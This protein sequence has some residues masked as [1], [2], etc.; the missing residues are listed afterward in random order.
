M[1]KTVGILG[2]GQLGRMMCEAA[3]RLNLK[4]VCLDA[5][6]APAK[7]INCHPDHVNGSFR[8]AQA[9]RRLAERCDVLTTEIEHVDTYALE[10]LANGTH[11]TEDWQMVKVPRVDIQPGWETI[12]TIQDK[13]LQKEHL[14]AHQVSTARSLPLA[15][16]TLEALQEC[17]T[18]LKLPFMLKSRTEAYDGRGN[19]P[20]KTTSDFA[21]ALEALGNRQLYAEEWQNFKQELAVMIVKTTDDPGE[22]QSCT[23][24]F[25]VVETVHEDS[26]CKLVYAPARAV[27]PVDSQNAQD[28]AR[29]AVSTFRGKGVFGVEMFLLDNGMENDSRCILRLMEYRETSCQRDCTTSP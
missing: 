18:E 28:L 12:R 10:E 29:K 6:G 19:H 2:G 13:Y 22:W 27:S 14:T 25:P 9:I 17:R 11:T 7:Q 23:L 15:E 20:V 24:A 21:A 16:N 3:S 4:V 5:E 26:I 1:E 8:D